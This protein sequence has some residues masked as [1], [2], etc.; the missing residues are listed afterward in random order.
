MN[1][2]IYGC[3][4]PTL[5]SCATMFNGTTQNINIQT[6]HDIAINQTRCEVSNEEGRWFIATNSSTSIHRDGNTMN[7]QC[8]NKYQTSMVSIDPNFNPEWILTDLIF[9]L[10]TISCIVDGYNNS[11]YGY[12]QRVTVNMQSK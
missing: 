7:I 4:L 5:I 10:C 12:P 1:K 8:S 2:L 9:D 3:L 11:W 6:L